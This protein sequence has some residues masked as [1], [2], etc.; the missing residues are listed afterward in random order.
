MQNRFAAP[1]GI[2]L[3]V[4]CLAGCS[5]PQ[6]PGPPAAGVTI[7]GSDALQTQA[8][9]CRQLQWTWTIDIG[10]AASGANLSVGTGEQKPAAISVHINNVGGF[11]GMYSQSD[12]AADTR[13]SGE[14]FTIAGTANGI[15]TDTKEPASAQYKIVA[16]C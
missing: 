5:S 12:G 10:D 1:A 13:V 3:T 4:A 14:T 6:A 2:A 9:T 8:V 11:S 15:R 7:N 16:R